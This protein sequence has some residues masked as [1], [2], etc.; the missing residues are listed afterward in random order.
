LESRAINPAPR[1]AKQ[2]S[3]LQG[4]AVRITFTGVKRNGEYIRRNWECNRIF[5]KSEKE[6]KSPKTP[7]KRRGKRPQIT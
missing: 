7:G 1:R 4:Y 5:E 3:V 6:A 2:L